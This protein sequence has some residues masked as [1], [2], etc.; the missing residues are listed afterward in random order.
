M[1]KASHPG[2]GQRGMHAIIALRVRRQ[3]EKPQHPAYVGQ[4]SLSDLEGVP[5]NRVVK[6]AKG[7]GFSAA[8][9]TLADT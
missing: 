8:N 2:S 4:S 6:Y 3:I 9:I 1:W 5:N 7:S